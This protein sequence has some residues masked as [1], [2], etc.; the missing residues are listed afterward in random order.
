MLTKP[1][2]LTSEVAEATHHCARAF[3]I[4]CNEDWHIV[5]VSPEFSELTGYSA[6]EARGLM[7]CD[8][9]HG[10]ET[11]EHAAKRLKE[12]AVHKKP[13][14]GAM[15]NYR[16]DGTPFWVH[17]G[18]NPVFNSRREFQYFLAVRTIN[19][20]AE[21]LEEQTQAYVSGLE[22][23]RHVLI[24]EVHHRIKNSLQGV[25]GM[26]RQ[27]AHTEP[28]AAPIL[29]KAI[30]QVRTIAVV[31]G[32]EGKALYNEVVL[33]EMVPSIVHMVQELVLPQGP[34]FEIIVN[35]PE[36]IRVCE[37]E[38]VPVA[39]ILNELIL[40]AAKYFSRS[41]ETHELKISVVWHAELEC[42]R[43]AITNPG[44]LPADFNFE[45]ETATGTGLALVKSLLPTQGATLNFANRNGY[46]ETQLTL[47]P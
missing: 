26:L 31:H 3:A 30:A 34:A 35:V 28:L 15:L 29:E 24:R 25:A 11:D 38:R 16:K 44:C 23:Q 9:L 13:Y 19:T 40:N 14:S 7:P 39:L 17:L 2:L 21:L 43:I 1:Q 22:R 8:L 12:C 41:G 20:Y 6:D 4:I 10:P 18:F 27:H 45:N 32:L 5:W 37:Q 33:C 46:V 36:R 47:S 42:A